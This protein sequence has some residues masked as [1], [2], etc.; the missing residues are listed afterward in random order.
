MK[1]KFGT[2]A[3][4]LTRKLDPETSH[5]AAANVD[6]SHLEEIVYQ[7]ILSA[8]DRG[9]IADEL[10]K[11]VPHIRRHSLMPR[12]APLLRKGLIY[13]NGDKRKGQAMQFVLRASRRKTVQ[14]VL[15]ERRSIEPV[16]KKETMG[17]LRLRIA[18]LETRLRVLVGYI[19]GS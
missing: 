18:D 15:L 4:M 1:E 2:P 17:S 8:G 11:A 14:L 10:D 16:S 6:T 13:R 5:T 9:M 12:C 3:H 7:A 19:P